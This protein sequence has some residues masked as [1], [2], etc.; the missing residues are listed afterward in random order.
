MSTAQPLVIAGPAII[1]ADLTE[2]IRIHVK[3]RRFRNCERMLNDMHIA[4]DPSRFKEIAVVHPVLKTSIGRLSIIADGAVCPPGELIEL[5]ELV[6][7]GLS[8]IVKGCRNGDRGLVMDGC[9]RLAA[10]NVRFGR[11]QS[12]SAFL[13]R[14]I[15][16]FPEG[17]N[18]RRRIATETME[19]AVKNKE[20][21]E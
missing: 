16:D 12:E 17:T 3:A 13:D 21:T 8:E 5:F 2:Q 20:R 15:S 4:V 19:G 10:V 6:D 9:L 14:A 1:A 7:E 11:L 18:L